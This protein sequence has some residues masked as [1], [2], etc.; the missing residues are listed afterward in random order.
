MFLMLVMMS[1]YPRNYLG[2]SSDARA[3]SRGGAFVV[4]P[5]VPGSGVAH[6]QHVSFPVHI[7]SVLRLSPRRPLA[8]TGDRFIEIHVMYHRRTRRPYD[9]V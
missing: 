6:R 9:A 2:A 7:F 5:S 8:L 3:P 1:S 4:G